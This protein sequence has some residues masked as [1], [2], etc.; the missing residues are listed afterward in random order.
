MTASYISQGI[1]KRLYHGGEGSEAIVDVELRTEFPGI[2]GTII[3]AEGAVTA[4]RQEKSA[5]PGQAHQTYL[6]HLLVKKMEDFFY[7]T[8]VYYF[9]HVP[10]PLGSISEPSENV[11]AY[12]YEWA[13]GS[14]GF[15]WEQPDYDNRGGTVPVRLD[16]Y[17][18]VVSAFST[19][20][21]HIGDDVCEPD[22]GRISKNIIHQMPS[23]ITPGA[24]E[25]NL[26]WKRI[27]YGSRS[28]HMNLENLADYISAHRSEMSDVLR[29][30]RLMMMEH[31]IE[32]LVK[33]PSG[34][35]HFKIGQLDALIGDYREQTLYHFTQK[36]S[37]CVRTKPL[38][39]NRTESLI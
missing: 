19:A 38:K 21:I 5:T 2:G 7:R 37:G 31:T 30:E 14:E 3:T 16:D 17:N 9:A 18:V 11:E 39:G 25:L 27:D 36:G 26:L 12:M 4:F 24:T 32:F 8:N 28:L 33:G 35:D 23:V 6:R 15:P 1:I 29:P 22:D 34:M 13:Y 20:G 10:R